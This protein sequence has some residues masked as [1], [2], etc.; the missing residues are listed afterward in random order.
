MEQQNTKNIVIYHK[1]CPD[2]EMSAAIFRNKY[3]KIDI[4]YEIL[5]N[6]IL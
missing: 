2:G 4:D 1:P 6:L 3:N 5:L